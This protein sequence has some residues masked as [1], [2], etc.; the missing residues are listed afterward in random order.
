MS[1]WYRLPSVLEIGRDSATREPGSQ[2]EQD[3]DGQDGTPKRKGTDR[4]WQLTAVLA[5]EQTHGGI[6]LHG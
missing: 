1:R 3:S 2:Q 4:H 6:K 5:A